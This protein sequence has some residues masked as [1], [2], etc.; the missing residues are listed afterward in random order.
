MILGDEKEKDKKGKRVFQVDHFVHYQ[1]NFVMGEEE[2]IIETGEYIFVWPIFEEIY[3][4]MSMEK[5]GDVSGRISL[6]L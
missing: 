2:D 4:E 6:A 5:F 1:N 3:S